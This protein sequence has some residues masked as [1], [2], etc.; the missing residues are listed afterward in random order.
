[1][2]KPQPDDVALPGSVLSPPV[3]DVL[4]R[5]AQAGEV[6]ILYLGD[7]FD[8]A[9]LTAQ[10]FSTL[11][12]A[13][14]AAGAE[15]RLVLSESA[16]RGLDDALRAGLRNASYRCGFSVWTGDR[17]RAPNGALMIAS[18]G[19]SGGVTGFFSR[20]ATAIAIGSGW[21]T[22]SE[23]P[24]VSA[25]L[26]QPPE[27]QQVPADA[28]ERSVRPGDRVRIIDKDPGRPV[29]QFGVGFV[30]RFL[31]DELE[32]AGLWKPGQ[33]AGIA[34]ADRYLKAPLP[35]LLMVRVAA[36]LRDQL[37]PKETRIR[38]S[39]TTEP[40]KHDPYRGAPHRLNNNW[41]DEAD[42]AETIEA[43]AGRVGFDCAYNDHSASH[44]RKLT[45]SY[46]DGSEAVVLLD[47]G[48]GY[49]RSTG[50]DRHDFRARPVQQ[51]KAMLDATA[52]VA[53]HGESYVAVTRPR[54]SPAGT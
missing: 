26:S 9:E 7:D 12:N 28:L 43:L 35:V 42:R 29:K 5:K 11:F 6:A 44:G 54:S 20:D 33:L 47:Q 21:G 34:Y 3:A 40:L 49:W 52:F 10:P 53:G 51:A 48:F 4:V 14:A 1:M 32:A 27:L 8:L 25:Q 19:H 31:K 13:L 2:A 16:L 46:A 18:H 17:P 24:V 39:I 41:Q 37:A 22:G 38:L 36:A 45:L 23:H 15:A 50:A 30:A